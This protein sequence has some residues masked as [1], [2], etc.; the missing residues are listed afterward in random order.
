MR[1][2]TKEEWK[3][4][5]GYEGLYQISNYGSVLGLSSG[6][7]LKPTDVKSRGV[8]AK[9]IKNTL[10]KN[11]KLKNFTIHNLV[12]THF[13]GKIKGILDFKDGDYRNCRLDNLIDV[14]YTYNQRVN[15]NIRVLDKSTGILYS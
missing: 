10:S 8:Y 5:K 1:M 3:D 15:K 4:I 9:R 13:F 11:G 7:I 14:D 12:Y 2:G 6:K